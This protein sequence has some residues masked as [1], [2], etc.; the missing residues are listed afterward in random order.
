MAKYASWADFERNVPEAYRQNA[1]PTAYRAG[2]TQI[3]PPGTTPRADRVDAYG[4]GVDGKA[5][6]VVSGYRRAMFA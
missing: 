5:E 6:R 4:R 1:T 3:A 2:L